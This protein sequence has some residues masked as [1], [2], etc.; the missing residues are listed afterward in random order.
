MARF[1]L[2]SKTDARERDDK[3]LNN[4]DGQPNLTIGSV[5][6]LNEAKIRKS[7]P[8]SSMAK[9]NQLF[10]YYAPRLTDA[11]HDSKAAGR[12]LRLVLRNFLPLPLD[13]DVYLLFL[14]LV[15]E[16]ID[17]D[18]AESE[19]AVG[20]AG[21]V[22]NTQN[23]ILSQQLDRLVSVMER[24]PPAGG[25]PPEAL[26]LEDAARFLGVEVAS[27]EH[28]VKSR[29]LAYVQVGE[30]RVRVIRVSDLTNFAR[31]RRQPTGDELQQKRVRKR[32][33]D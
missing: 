33:P 17:T 28:L 31:E 18:D 7:H 27:I 32:S 9:E 10:D 22:S 25:L 12:H 15:V 14:Q 11:M 2:R 3:V 16:A 24:T 23:T 26:S 30:Q 8:P 13:G 19:S 29:K 1:P 6:G 5:F 20:V 21:M 4:P